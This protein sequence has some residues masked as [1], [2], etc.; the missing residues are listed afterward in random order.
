MRTLALKVFLER[1][2]TDITRRSNDHDTQK[3]LDIAAEQFS[4]AKS[5]QHRS[6]EHPED[7]D[8]N[9]ENP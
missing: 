6:Y 5:E 3:P 7:A 9:E 2:E 4:L 1:L 8:R